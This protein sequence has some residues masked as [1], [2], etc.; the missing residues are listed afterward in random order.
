MKHRQGKLSLV[1][2]CMHVSQ[3][4]YPQHSWELVLPLPVLLLLLLHNHH[5]SR[6]FGSVEQYPIGLQMYARN[7]M[8]AF[9]YYQPYNTFFPPPTSFRPSRPPAL[10]L[11]PH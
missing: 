5:C 8:A 10:Q 9:S 7:A 2:S 4:S 6:Y 3:T 1:L 11:E